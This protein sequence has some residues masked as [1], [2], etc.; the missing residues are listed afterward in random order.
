MAERPDSLAFRPGVGAGWTDI[1]IDEGAI[2][3]HPVDVHTAEL[4]GENPF[5]YVSRH[6]RARVARSRVVTARRVARGAGRSAINVA[7]LGTVL[8]IK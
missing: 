7:V 8:A 5:E 3:L 4:H 2:L 1:D 6:A